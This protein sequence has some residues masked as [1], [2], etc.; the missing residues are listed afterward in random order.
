MY[1]HEWFRWSHR[2]RE[3]VACDVFVVCGVCRAWSNRIFYNT[4]LRV[5]RLLLWDILPRTGLKIKA[6]IKNT[7]ILPSTQ[8]FQVPC[9]SR[10]WER[11]SQLQTY[12]ASR[13]GMHLP[14]VACRGV[15]RHVGHQEKQHSDE[16]E[17]LWEM[18]SLCFRAARLWKR[19]SCRFIVSPLFI[20]I[21]LDADECW[22]EIIAHRRWKQIGFDKNDCTI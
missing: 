21:L 9:P 2:V 17:I 12:H 15:G 11:R 6:N 10:R 22:S 4:S 20:L 14:L 13:T 3:R 7:A 18:C 8:S 16:R 19:W 5:P 1:G